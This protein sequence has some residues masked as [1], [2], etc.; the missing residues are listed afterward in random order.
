MEAIRK[1]ASQANNP[2]HFLGYGIPNFKA[3]VNYVEQSHQENVFDV[4]PNPITQD[5][6]TIRPFD[7]NQVGF[8][9][10]EVLTSQG[11]TVYEANV[12]F[13]WANRTYTSHVTTLPTGVYFMRIWWGD[14]RFTYKVI[15]G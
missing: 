1:S 14:K 13:S 10:V 11:Q 2:D 3:V 5:S 4:Y 7:P 8:C 9:K 6:I 15:K 12:N